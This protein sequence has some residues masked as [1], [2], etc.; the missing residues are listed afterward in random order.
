MIAAWCC[1]RVILPLIEM[2]RYAILALKLLVDRLACFCRA[3]LVLAGKVQGKWAGEFFGLLQIVLN[4]NCIV[5][6]RHVCV[7]AGCG[8]IGQQA[9]EAVADGTHLAFHKSLTAQSRDGVLNV[10]Q[11]LVHIELLIETEGFLEIL[12]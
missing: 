8:K 3:E 12:F 6:D 7:S 10:L 2:K 11:S 1:E 4:A 9:A 5:A